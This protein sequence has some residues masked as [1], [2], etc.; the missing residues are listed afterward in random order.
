LTAFLIVCAVALV[1]S[2]L[3]L[4]SGFGL[5]TLLLPAFALVFPIEIAVSATAVVHLLNNLFKLA[6]IGRAA[7]RGAL[8]RFGVP[9]MLAAL[10][11]AWVLSRLAGLPT[12]FEYEL[13]GGTRSITATRLAVAVLIFAFALLDLLPGRDGRGFDRRFM[14]LGGALSGFFGGLSGH[15]GALRSA[16]LINAGLGKEAFVGTGVAC[17]VLVDLSRLTVYGAA[18]LTTHFTVLGREDGYP[19][20]IAATLSAFAGAFVGVR[21]LGKMTLPTLRRVVG[22][23]LIVVALA[24][25]AGLV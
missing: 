20:M 13:W 14:P 10:A 25:G 24:L 2:A 21:V 23:L 22:A 1:A 4:V 6:L 16:F 3:T 11:G 15:Q 8:L 12:L 19:L 5:G 17:A 9:A 18:F 7:D